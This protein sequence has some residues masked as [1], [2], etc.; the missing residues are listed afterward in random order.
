MIDARQFSPVEVVRAFLEQIDRLNPSLNAYLTVAGDEAMASAR[1][2]E[3]AVMRGENLG[4][5]H[6][7]P[8]SAKDLLITRGLRTTFGSL[9]FQDHVPEEDAVVVVRVK[10]AGAILLGK[11]NTPEFGALVD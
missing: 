9:V 10:A 2:A 11:T 8:F 6:G 4:P 1:A 3:A 5:L 7:V